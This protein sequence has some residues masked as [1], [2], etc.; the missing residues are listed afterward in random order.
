MTS[1]QSGARRLPITP[2]LT[3][4]GVIALVA[5]VL[6]TFSSGSDAVELG[7]PAISGNAL[8]RLPQGAADPAIG[9]EAPRVEGEDFDG[10]PVALD[11]DGEAKIIIFLAHWCPHCQ[12]EVPIVQDWLDG[13][14][15]PDG[16]AF[17]SV[18]TSIQR[19]REN[20]PPS[21]W[22]EREGWEPP[23]IVDDG[24]SSVANAFGLTAFPFWVFVDADGTV[25][26][27][28]S[29]GIPPA[30]LDQIAAELAQRAG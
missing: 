9:M 10:E 11:Q 12:R 21:S 19:T 7:E 25:A 29:G 17:Y 3:G 26:G 30:D 14:P 24:P 15:L 5:T 13:G 6:L 23:V 8:P 22:L 16:V 20:Y 1:G 28:M 2:I 18:A 27:R 4:I